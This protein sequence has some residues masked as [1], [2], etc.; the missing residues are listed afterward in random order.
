[1][2]SY[3]KDILKPVVRSGDIDRYHATPSTLVLFPYSIDGTQAK[4]INQ[5]H[6]KKNFPL[7]WEYLCRNRKLLEQREK[8]K[9]KDLEWYR[10]GR[11]QNL[12]MWE[13][14]KLMI[15]YMIRRLAAHLDINE[16]LYFIN[17]TT[18]GYGIIGKQ[19]VSLKY[20][21]GLL[22]SRLLDYCF[23]NSSTTF[24]GGYFA[25]NKQF[26]E[27]LPIRIINSSDPAEVAL[28]NNLIALVEQMLK[29][30]KDIFD[31]LIPTQK[32]SLQRQIDA[33]DT[34]IDHLVYDLYGLTDEEIRVVE[35]K[36]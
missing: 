28:Y 12:G 17:V 16:K 23:K 32:T 36:I 26:I 29:L 4:L 3:E 1:V 33:T 14:S 15:P 19:D 24:H 31:A 18:G 21:C 9:F 27:Q 25:A 8:G 11:T 34:Q 2:S 5:L 30:Q 6:M 7:A 13:Q 35:G 10:F 22:N 20:L